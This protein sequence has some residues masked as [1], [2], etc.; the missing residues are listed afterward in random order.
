VNESA[1]S[2]DMPYH[3]RS[4][5]AL[6]KLAGQEYCRLFAELY[7][8]ETVSLC[9]FNV[10]GPH[11]DPDGAYALVVGKFLRQR[12]N[13]EPLTIC[14]DGEYYRDYTHVADVVRANVLAMES[15][16]VGNGELVNIGNGRPCSVN[17]L[18]KI[19]G[20]QT[21][22][23]PPRPGDVRYT[24]ADNTLAKEL[25]GWEPTIKLEDGIRE[26]KKEWGIQNEE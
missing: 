5:Y 15:E 11:L 16:R 18:A 2:E 20:G 25:L 3:P 23:V 7:G 24:K 10:Y 21:I 12:K 26:L 8:L 13:N 14:G 17:T 19:I 4:P 6:Q 22:F 1:V 9:Y